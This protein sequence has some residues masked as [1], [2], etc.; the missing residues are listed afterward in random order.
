MS[1]EEVLS[2]SESNEPTTS[3]VSKARCVSVHDGKRCRWKE[4][5]GCGHAWWSRKEARVTWE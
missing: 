1:D 4:G 5:H 3:I 2:G